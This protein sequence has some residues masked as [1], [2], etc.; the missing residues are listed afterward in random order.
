VSTVID[1]TEVV[2]PEEYLGVL[3]MLGPDDPPKR[4][5][6][7]I[8]GR[9]N[10]PAAPAAPKDWDSTAHGKAWRAWVDAGGGG[11]DRWSNNNR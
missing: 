8:E 2:P 7:V 6:Q 10:P 4:S 3:P 5:S 11:G 9:A 1:P